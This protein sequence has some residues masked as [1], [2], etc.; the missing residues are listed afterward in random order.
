M[1][2][3]RVYISCRRQRSG[4]IVLRLHQVFLPVA[5]HI[6]EAV[7]SFILGDQTDT[8]RNVLRRHFVDQFCSVGLAPAPQDRLRTNGHT[9][10]LEQIRTELNQRYFE[11]RSTARITWG[12]PGPDRRRYRISLGSYDFTGRTITVHPLLEQP[13]VPRYVVEQTIHHE[14]LHEMLGLTW[15]GTRRV[16]HPPA[17]RQLE[18]LYHDFER[19]QAWLDAHIDALLDKTSDRA[20]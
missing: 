13:H 20:S 14:M 4:T 5:P 16:L 1:R 7:E 10:D 15:S 11:G 19:A 6:R 9:H 12:R 18:R 17:F 2:N 3:R 8:A